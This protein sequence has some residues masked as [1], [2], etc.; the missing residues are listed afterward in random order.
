M[1]NNFEGLRK[2]KSLLSRV[3]I[4]E[5]LIIWV[6]IQRFVVWRN[7]NELR[8]DVC[9]KNFFWKK[10]YLYEK[11]CVKLWIFWGKKINFGWVKIKSDVSIS[12]L[13][14]MI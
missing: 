14:K 2:R 11:Q 6:M 8:S 4:V 3:K 1:K 10:N 12:I 9:I 7:T 13:K 5:S